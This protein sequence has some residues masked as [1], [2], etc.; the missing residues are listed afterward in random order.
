MFK[1]SSGVRRGFTLVE[2]LVV[3]AIIGVLV[4]L[5]LP[6]VQQAREAARRAECSNNLKQI[7]LALHNYHSTH[8][9]LPYGV[10][11]AQGWGFSWWVAAL[12]YIEQ[13]AG[14]DQLKFVGGH[15]GWAHNNAGRVG[16]F[17]GEVFRGLEIEAMSCPSSPLDKTKNV[18]SGIINAVP[19]YDGISGAIND[20]FTGGFTNSPGRQEACCH[21]CNTS[22]RAGQIASGGVLVPNELIHFGKIV[23]G[24]S[25]TIAVGECSN[26]VDD[27]TG[28]KT[29]FINNHHG[30]LMGSPVRQKVNGG[31]KYW[32]SFNITSIWYPPNS[33]NVQMPGVE[34][35]DGQNDGL[36]SAH[37]GGAQV[38]SADGS[39]HFVPDNINITTLKR[40]CNR[41]DGLTAS[42][43]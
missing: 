39:V 14:Y 28:R 9:T 42:I 22:A 15:P 5:L 3:I 20:A 4:A 35:N 16:G 37:P 40:L 8:K 11:G 6:A 17:N 41:D 32:R 2:L 27:G 24:T 12:P 33:V 25:N 34:I 1:S 38:A 10:A 43:D 18:G 23:D 36:Y 31:G 7:G 19:Q 30:F 13:R 26:F 29:R 21:C